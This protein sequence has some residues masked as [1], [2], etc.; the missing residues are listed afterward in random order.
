[1][2]LQQIGPKQKE[3][4]AAARQRHQLEAQILQASAELEMSVGRAAAEAYGTSSH[5]RSAVQ[6][7]QSFE[8]LVSKSTFEML[9]SASAHEVV[10][11]TNE[12]LKA[13]GRQ[14]IAVPLDQQQHTLRVRLPR[15]VCLTVDDLQA[16]SDWAEENLNPTVQPDQIGFVMNMA[17]TIPHMLQKEVLRGN[18]SDWVF[19]STQPLGF[20]LELGCWGGGDGASAGHRDCAHFTFRFM[21]SMS[22]CRAGKTLFKDQR[23][24]V[25]ENWMKVH[26]HEKKAL[27]RSIELRLC[28]VVE[29]LSTIFRLSLPGSSAVHTISFIP[30]DAANA[31][32]PFLGFV[33]GSR[34]QNA[35]YKSSVDGSP[36]FDMC[37]RD[38][39][40][41]KRL[42]LGSRHKIWQANK[43]WM[44]EEIA[45]LDPQLGKTNRESAI[46]KLRARA[47]LLFCNTMDCPE[48][49][50]DANA[51]PAILALTGTCR[52]HHDPLHTSKESIVSV[53][54]SALATCSGWEVVDGLRVPTSKRGNSVTAAR[55]DMMKALKASSPG[56]NRAIDDFW[57]TQWREVIKEPA[58]TSIFAPFCGEP[59]M[60]LCRAVELSVALQAAGRRDVLNPHVRALK[61]IV[62]LAHISLLEVMLACTP[63]SGKFSEVKRINKIHNQ[64][65]AL[66]PDHQTDGV[67]TTAQMTEGAGSSFRR[68]VNLMGSNSLSAIHSA[69]VHKVAMTGMV[70]AASGVCPDDREEAWPAVC[71]EWCWVHLTIRTHG[72]FHYSIDALDN[73]AKRCVFWNR[74]RGCILIVPPHLS[75]R[76]AKEP[77]WIP[78]NAERW[79]CGKHKSQCQHGGAFPGN[80]REVT[81]TSYT[82]QPLGFLVSDPLA[83]NKQLQ[84]LGLS[85]NA[86][87]ENPTP[88][89]PCFCDKPSL[90]GHYA[91]R[92]DREAQV[93]GP[94][95]S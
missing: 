53:W 69:H 84:R 73:A 74:E 85:P 92:R 76:A 77:T 81:C 56:K 94:F 50:W 41:D 57:Q 58:R 49:Y 18:I 51:D 88:R 54:Y 10:E 4:R 82:K 44:S 26:L 64:A 6:N 5:R 60:A 1:M 59:V 75:Q 70:A 62:S 28:Q 48:P 61:T 71:I 29:T 45:K 95:F 12:R 68:A 27:A 20:C 22:A 16:M 7:K 86:D 89:C 87:P 9:R 52:V 39:V 2:T 11:A 67:S 43:V 37:K 83:T 91:P 63:V 25:W 19:D 33:T 93:R 32:S 23:P 72:A 42:S 8:L 36:S 66:A 15:E 55:T 46:A 17:S 3:W 34:H 14:P 21:D 38:T 80:T 65:F 30:A 24:V 13:A 78:A 79:C 90:P 40:A 47:R 31:D 35:V